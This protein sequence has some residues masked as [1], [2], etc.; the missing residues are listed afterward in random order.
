MQESTQ[1]YGRGCFFRMEIC[2]NNFIDASFI[3]WTEDEL[4]F[5]AYGQQLYFC[6]VDYMQ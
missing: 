5:D 3:S 6:V 4:S 1:S 2:Y